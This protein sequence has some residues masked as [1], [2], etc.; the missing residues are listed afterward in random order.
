VLQVREVCQD[1]CTNDKNFTSNAM[2]ALQEAA[3]VYVTETFHKANM[4][5]LHAG[6]ETVNIKVGICCCAL[7]SM[8]PIDR[9]GFMNQ[10]D[11]DT[12]T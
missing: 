9:T 5:R 8:H 6:R 1:V 12:R 7:M 10:V 2:K 3:E 4:A 11:L